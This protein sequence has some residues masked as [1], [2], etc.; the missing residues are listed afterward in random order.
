LSHFFLSISFF[1]AM[2]PPAA[3]SSPRPPMGA[4]VGSPGKLGWAITTVIK[5]STNKAI[6]VSLAIMSCSYFKKVN[7]WLNVLLPTFN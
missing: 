1:I 2:A 5:G 6:R 3:A 7:F 4:W